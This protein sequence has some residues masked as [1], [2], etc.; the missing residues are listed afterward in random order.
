MSVNLSL[1]FENKH[2]ITLIIKSLIFTVLI[3]GGTVMIISGMSYLNIVEIISN[4]SKPV[5]EME[6][7]EF[8]TH[9]EAEL[10][11]YFS[12]NLNPLKRETNQSGE[13]IYF[14]AYVQSDELFE[15]FSVGIFHKDLTERY[16]KMADTYVSDDSSKF[17]KFRNNAEFFIDMKNNNPEKCLIKN[18]EKEGELIIKSDCSYDY[19]GNILQILETPGEYYAIFVNE[20]MLNQRLGYMYPLLVFTIKDTSEIIVEQK[21]INIDYELTLQKYQNL[22]TEGYFFLGLGTGMLFVCITVYD[23]IIHEK[24]NFKHEKIKN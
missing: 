7:E 5:V 11:E 17:T 12:L 18:P 20:G 16:F 3:I 23:S 9:P 22:K 19:N 21:L 15:N 10:I 4:V 13:K 6:E 24:R 2:Q 8:T 1:S 14:S